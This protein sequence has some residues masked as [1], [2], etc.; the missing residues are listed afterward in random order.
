[1]FDHW[2]GFNKKMNRKIIYLFNPISGTTR[3]DALL[4]KVEAATKSRNF[5]FEFIK[6]NSRGDYEFLKGK[7]KVEKITDVVIIGGD[8]TVNQ[9]TGVSSGTYSG[10]IDQ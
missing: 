2:R 10:A 1:M 8:G 4:N 6:T 7:I 3:K 9:V 5:H